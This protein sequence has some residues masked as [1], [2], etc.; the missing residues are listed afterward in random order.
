MESLR[1][2]ER[3]RDREKKGV[4]EKERGR[5]REREKERER[6]RKRERNRVCERNK[7]RE[8]KREKKREK[9]AKN[10]NLWASCNPVKAEVRR[11]KAAASRIEE[12][13]SEEESKLKRGE[14]PSSANVV[15]LVLC[16]KEEQGKQ[17]HLQEQQLDASGKVRPVSAYQEKVQ[18]K[19]KQQV[20][21]WRELC[22][23]GIYQYLSGAV[24][25]WKDC[26][27][28]ATFVE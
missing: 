9:D 8:R 21:N 6:E 4:W 7:E 28:C 22:R 2:R 14:E 11:K 12:L 23:M 17:L 3:K 27:K 19:V 1:E 10:T 5:E 25:C 16:E 20:M 24:I 26:D 15:D 18:I 13:L